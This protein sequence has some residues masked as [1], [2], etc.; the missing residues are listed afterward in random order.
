MKGKGQD[1]S[2]RDVDSSTTA[3][4]SAPEPIGDERTAA[5]GGSTTREAGRRPSREDAVE[6]IASE[7]MAPD[8]VAKAQAAEPE[9]T[10][11]VP[12]VVEEGGFRAATESDPERAVARERDRGREAYSPVG[13]PPKGWWDIVRRVFAKVVAQNVSI[14]A[15]GVAFYA[16]LALFPALGAIVTTYALIADPT[17]VSEHFNQ[18]S[19]IL[20]PDVASIIDRQLTALASRDQGLGL[21]LVLGLLFAIWSA[22][23]GVDALVRAITVAYDEKETRN[24]IKMNA[25]TYVLTLGAVMLLVTTVALLVALPTAL[26][27]LP[28]SALT[29]FAARA[30]SWVIFFGVM[31]LAISLLYRF[32][33]PRRSARWRWLSPGAFLATVL[34]VAGSAGFSLYVTSFGSYNETYGTLGAIIVLLLWF[35]LSAFSIVLGAATNAE[36]EHQT[37]RDTTVGGAQPMGQR[38]AYVADTLGE[39]P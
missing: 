19:G 29:T 31:I 39:I 38:G 23:R 25:L 35:F 20:P 22:R 17:D 21:Q 12:G 14:L 6:R 2:K 7:R 26:A 9:E 28:L 10:P 13:I 5:A 32:A 36:M 1:E 34:W 30:G 37:A 18:L 16:M 24:I 27:F 33:P 8:E 4:R 3:S 15:A 11:D